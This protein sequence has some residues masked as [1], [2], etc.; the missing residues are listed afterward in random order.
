MDAVMSECRAGVFVVDDHDVIHGGIAR[1][2]ENSESLHFLGSTASLDNALLDITAADPDVV[3]LDLMLGDVPSWQLCEDIVRE[4]DGV[5]VIIYSA[6]GSGQSVETAL[7]YGASAYQLKTGSVQALGTVIG[8]VLAGGTVID[9]SLTT[10]WVRHR[11]NKTRLDLDQRQLQ[12]LECIADGKDN[13]Q[14]SEELTVS[15]HTVKFH[16]SK[17]LKMSGEINRAGLV[18]FGKENFIIA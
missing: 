11:R 12:I 2:C 5:H 14:I 10:D 15:Y 8:Q 6:F 18:R 1:I 4:V 7:K 9:P 13:Y 16:I 3:I 17:M